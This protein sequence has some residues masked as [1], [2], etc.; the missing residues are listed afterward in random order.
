[1]TAG[2]VESKRDT[3]F[4]ILIEAFTNSN[5]T[6]DTA[7]TI[8]ENLFQTASVRQL[9]GQFH[10]IQRKI[11]FMAEGFTDSNANSVIMHG[12]ILG[13]NAKKIEGNQ[14]SWEIK[15]EEF[16]IKDYE[17]WVESRIVNKWTIWV[18]G[19]VMVLSSIVLIV[20]AVRRPGV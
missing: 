18:T 3:L 17:M 16:L 8:C 6:M 2:I 15:A 14:V 13:T 5:A 19:I 4:A 20:P 1:M 9:R 11:D 7:I 12:L 10:R